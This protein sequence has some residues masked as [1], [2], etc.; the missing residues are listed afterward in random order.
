MSLLANLDVY[1][2]I[3]RYYSVWGRGRVRKRRAVQMIEMDRLEISMNR[4][5]GHRVGAYGHEYPWNQ[6]KRPAP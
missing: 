6:R 3:A 1:R 2:K 5:V 4:Q